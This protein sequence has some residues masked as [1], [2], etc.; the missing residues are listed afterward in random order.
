MTSTKRTASMKAAQ[1][2]P[3]PDEIWDTQIWMPQIHD[4]TRAPRIPGLDSPVC[5]L[6]VTSAKRGTRLGGG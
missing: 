2:N 6:A 1:V 5:P 4:G 3:A